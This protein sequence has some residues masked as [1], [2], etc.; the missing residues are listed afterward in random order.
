VGLLGDTIAKIAGEKAGIIKAERAVVIGESNPESDPVFRNKAA[1]CGSPIIFADKEWSVEKVAPLHT[2][3]KYALH[4]A[5]GRR[6]EL[7]SDLSGAAYQRHN[8][9]TALAAIEALRGC[10]VRI[11]DR[12]ESEGMA[13]A[14]AATGLGGRWQVVSRSPLVVCD[15]AHNAHGFAHIATPIAAQKFEKLYMVL[16]FASDKALDPIIELLPRDTHYILTQASLERAMKA[17]RLAE[18]FAV[19]GIEGEIVASV[20]MAVKHALALASTEDMVYIGGSTF[21]VADALP[22]FSGNPR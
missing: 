18:I 21:V 16:G 9:V 13:H 22:Y 14:A 7:E 12:A 8:I 17:D 20:E 19:H 3:V 5:D 2:G 15:T 11:D 6:R 10:G 1:E 4:A